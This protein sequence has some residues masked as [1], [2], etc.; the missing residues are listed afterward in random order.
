VEADLGVIEDPRGVLLR[1]DL[2]DDR[3]LAFGSG[4]QA[5]GDRDRGLADAALA[6]D[7]DDALVE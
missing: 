6:G 7:E 4:P 3:P 5:E 2:A 1:R